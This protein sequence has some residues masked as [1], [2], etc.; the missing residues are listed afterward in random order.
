[1]NFWNGSIGHEEAD[2]S[3]RALETP[4]TYQGYFYGG[5][6]DPKYPNRMA[7]NLKISP[8]KRRR[9]SS[10][11]G[12]GLKLVLDFVFNHCG[13][14]PGVGFFGLPTDDNRWSWPWFSQLRKAN[15]VQEALKDKESKFRKFF[16]LGPWSDMGRS[17]IHKGMHQ[18]MWPRKRWPMLRCSWLTHSKAHCHI[19][20]VV[21]LNNIQ[22]RSQLHTSIDF[23][24]QANGQVD[25]EQIVW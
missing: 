5:P 12:Q 9:T 22:K 11:T 13:K 18:N 2:T 7:W 16:F 24:A 25:S 14:C 10:R 21:N 23:R 20:I 19:Y 15:F 8:F 17:K 6:W 3:C 1:M 4:G